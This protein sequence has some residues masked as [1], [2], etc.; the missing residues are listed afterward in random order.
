VNR[1]GG[2]HQALRRAALP[3]AVGQP[4]SRCGQPMLPGQALDLDHRD[5]GGGWWGFAH[6][7]C[8][9]A[10][11][12]RLG[13]ARRRDRITKTR[14]MTE[15]ALGVEIAEDRSH[16]SIVA[17]G[18]IDDSDVILIDLVAYLPG[19]DAAGVVLEL[20]ETRTVVAVA[21]DPH[22]PGATLIKPLEDARVRELRLPSTSDAVVAHGAF[23]DILAAGRLRHAG[24][25]E[26][27]A[28][29]RAGTQ[30]PI[31]GAMGWARR[32]EQVDG[33]P[34]RAATLA[35]WAWTHRPR[36]VDVAANVW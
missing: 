1:Y 8:N 22:S 5:D 34:L 27:T 16:T 32:G 18:A 7:R 31:G 28:A 4:C 21:V 30:R 35:V 23:L 12:G 24:Q 17:A 26:L 13:N 3:Y 33:A 20:R 9:R 2:P 6:A 29:V 15:V 36:V 11:G 19:T 25:P 10:A 14:A